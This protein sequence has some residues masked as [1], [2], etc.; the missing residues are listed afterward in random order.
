MLQDVWAINGDHLKRPHLWL[1]FYVPGWLDRGWLHI[2][3]A[4]AQPVVNVPAVLRRPSKAQSGEV[5]TLSE[6]NMVP[7]AYSVTWGD[8]HRPPGAESRTGVANPQLAGA[9]RLLPMVYFRF[10]HRYET[11]IQTHRGEASLLLWTP[12]VENTFQTPLDEAL[13]AAPILAYPQRRERGLS[14]TQTQ[15]TSGLEECCPKY[16]TDGSE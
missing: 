3:R 13:C 5:P 12:E 11:A 8:N 4:P 7:E 16:R 9:M 10:H 15:V 14:L 6:R 1:T 2:P